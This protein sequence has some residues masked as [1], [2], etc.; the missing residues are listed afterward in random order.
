MKL[1]LKEGCRNMQAAGLKGLCMKH[2]SQ[3]KKMITNG[4]TTWAELADLGMAELPAISSDMQRELAKRKKIANESDE[5]I[6]N[7]ET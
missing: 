1:C 2:Y 5:L 7:P 6:I 3:A 4:E